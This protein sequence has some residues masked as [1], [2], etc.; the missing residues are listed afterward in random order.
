MRM[1]N[2]ILI[3]VFILIRINLNSQTT[4]EYIK[5]GQVNFDAGNFNEA[6]NNYTRALEI[7]SL[8]I[9]GVFSILGVSLFSHSLN[10][11]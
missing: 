9:N 8:I 11:D 6:I 3:L 7:D 5:A 1:K 2:I 4:E 10:I